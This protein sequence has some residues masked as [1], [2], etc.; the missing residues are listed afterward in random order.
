MFGTGFVMLLIFCSVQHPLLWLCGACVG[1]LMLNNVT[2]YNSHKA[3]VGNCLERGVGNATIMLTLRSPALV[4]DE[5][6]AKVA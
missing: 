1:W 5:E 3:H 4:L 6:T 2:F